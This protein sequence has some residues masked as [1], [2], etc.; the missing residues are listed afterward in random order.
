[1]IEPLCGSPP[2][3]EAAGLGKQY[4][5]VAGAFWV[6]RGLDLVVQR[7]EM[8]CISGPSGCGKTTLLALLAGLERP[9]AGQVKLMGNRIDN[10]KESASAAVRRQTIGFVFQFFY[11]LPNL[12]VHENIAL[13]M[14]AAK[15]RRQDTRKA[16]ELAERLG[17]GQR[18]RHFPRQL[19]GGEQQR[20]ALAR[21]LIGDPSI[22]LAD[23][24]TG[25]LDLE[26][27]REVLSL[28][29]AQAQDGR[30]VLVVS[31]NRLVADLSDRELDLTRLSSVEVSR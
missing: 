8:V 25:N 7:G 27:A 19:S 16:A 2:A 13:P 1:V 29:R 28:L 6:F 4:R 5:S 21:A 14:M 31:H 30:T 20:V 3:V 9:T 24:P 11:L 12:T 15:P 17:L 18:L 22:I 10:L 26:S 23:E